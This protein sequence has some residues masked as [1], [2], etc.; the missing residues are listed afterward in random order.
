MNKQI[1]KFNEDFDFEDIDMTSIIKQ[2]LKNIE[3]AKHKYGSEYNQ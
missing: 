3:K 2:K 1:K